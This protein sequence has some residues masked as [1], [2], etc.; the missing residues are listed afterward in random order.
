MTDVK[1][2]IQDNSD[3]DPIT[4]SLVSTLINQVEASIKD[5]EVN[6]VN[7]LPLCILTMQLAERTTLKGTDKKQ[8]VMI[9]MNKLV[10]KYKGNIALLGLLPVFIDK[11]IALDKDQ[12]HIQERIK[13]SNCCVI[14]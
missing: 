9:I 4:E 14:V 10:E 1:T 13:N 2:N 11:A 5:G 7:L 8:L 3:S 6:A 12:F